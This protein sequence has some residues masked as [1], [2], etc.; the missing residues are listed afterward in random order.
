MARGMSASGIVC[1]AHVTRAH[2]LIMTSFILQTRICPSSPYLGQDDLGPGVYC[3]EHRVTRQ[4]TAGIG[5]QSLT[6]Q[7]RVLLWL[8]DLHA[9]ANQRI[10]RKHTQHGEGKST[11]P[12]IGVGRGVPGNSWPPIKM[13]PAPSPPPHPILGI[14]LHIHESLSSAGSHAPLTLLGMGMNTLLPMPV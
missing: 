13:S 5:C 9:G 14:T 2:I 7:T 3:R 6:G 10:H 11:P 1:A 4:G 12:H 8:T